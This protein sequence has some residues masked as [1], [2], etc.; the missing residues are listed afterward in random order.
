MR[1]RRDQ[2][3]AGGARGKIE[4]ECQRQCAAPGVA[5]HDGALDPQ[6]V[7]YIAQYGGLIGRRGALLRPARAK[8]ETGPV[9]EDD[10]A[11]PGKLLGERQVHVFQ[12]GA[13]AVQHRDRQR[14]VRV[15]RS[16]F[17]DVLRKAADIDEAAARAMRALDQ[18]RADEGDDGAGAQDCDDDRERGDHAL[19]L[20]P[21]PRGG[22]GGER[23][24]AGGG[25]Y[26][27][28][29]SKPAPSTMLRMVPLPRFAVE[30]NHNAPPESQRAP[31][32]YNASSSG[33]SIPGMSVFTL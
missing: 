12:I 24:R 32:A 16:H 14:I 8:A 22:G 17:D 27:F 3:Q 31:R 29:H 1:R 25:K 20:Y 15:A 10:A 30:D 26:R 6:P 11:A 23:K 9:D 21:P 33:P 5:D 13:G 28:A 2:H 7:Q 19:S 18:A 4:R